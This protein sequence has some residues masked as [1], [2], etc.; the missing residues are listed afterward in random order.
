V[1]TTA[2]NLV[3]SVNLSRLFF[4]QVIESLYKA[5]T[6]SCVSHKKVITA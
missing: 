3:G 4:Q 5:E 2:L 6:L 1:V